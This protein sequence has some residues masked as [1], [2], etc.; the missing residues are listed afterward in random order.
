MRGR[1]TFQQAECTEPL[2]GLSRF[3]LPFSLQDA[4]A[5]SKLISRP[6]SYMRYGTK[7]HW[8]Q[9]SVFA[10]PVNLAFRKNPFGWPSKQSV[11]NS[12]CLIKTPSLLRALRPSSHLLWKPYGSQKET[13]I[14]SKIKPVVLLENLLNRVERERGLFSVHG[15]SRIKSAFPIFLASAGGIFRSEIQG[16]D[17]CCEKR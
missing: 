11:K 17:R 4:E 5:A 9:V 7:F 2:D 10:F 16:F 3:N 12:Y 13:E 14:S 6:T 15:C 1:G 8:A